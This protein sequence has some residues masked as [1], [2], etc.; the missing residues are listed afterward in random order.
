[1]LIWW[2][3]QLVWRQHSKKWQI[4]PSDIDRIGLV[5]VQLRPWVFKA[6]TA[7]KIYC[8]LGR[9]WGIV[10]MLKSLQKQLQ[11]RHKQ[12]CLKIHTLFRCFSD[13]HFTASSA[14][15]KQCAGVIFGTPGTTYLSY[16]LVV[17]P[18]VYAVFPPRL[19]VRIYLSSDDC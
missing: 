7:T 5:H 1:M 11:R 4:S 15:R 8:E 14:N 10:S 19:S 18:N 16:S 17:S 3:L 13:G 2:G 6:A 12:Q 9:S